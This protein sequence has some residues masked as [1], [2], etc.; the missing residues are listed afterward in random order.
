MLNRYPF[1]TQ[2][3]SL[4]FASQVY[5]SAELLWKI[6]PG[7]NLST[8]IQVDSW[9]ILN[10]SLYVEERPEGGPEFNVGH[11]KNNRSYV[12][13]WLRLERSSTSAIMYIILP[14]L[15]ITF[16]NILC[17]ALPNGGK[18]HKAKYRDIF[19][20]AFVITV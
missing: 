3:C 13:Y 10:I 6:I 17:Y 4:I 11:T 14:T 12:I 5:T 1:D 2:Q 15:I 18:H 16:F 19:V 20:R 9:N 8:D 7:A